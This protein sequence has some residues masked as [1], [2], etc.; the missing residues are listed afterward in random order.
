M[1]QKLDSTYCPNGTVNAV[2]NSKAQ[3]AADSNISC[4]FQIDLEEAP[5][6][7]NMFLQL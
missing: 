3:L 2:L 7:K 1:H 4:K 5:V 6:I